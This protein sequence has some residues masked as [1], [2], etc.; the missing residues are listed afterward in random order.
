MSHYRVWRKRNYRVQH[1]NGKL[2]EYPAHEVDV[3]YGVSYK[4]EPKE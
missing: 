1:G 2:V 3:A 4:E